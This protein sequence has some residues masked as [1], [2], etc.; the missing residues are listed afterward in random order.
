MI[1][2]EHE[3]LPVSLERERY[4]SPPRGVGIWPRSRR[5]AEQRDELAPPDHSITS[6]AKM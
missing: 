6:S 4:V 3:Q 2:D 5:A 1:N